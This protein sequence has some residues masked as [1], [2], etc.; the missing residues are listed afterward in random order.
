MKDATEHLLSSPR[1]AARLRKAIADM[2]AGLGIERL[3]HEAYDD[4]LKEEIPERFT[5]LLDQLD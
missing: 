5:R 4:T 1:N 2:N 3:L